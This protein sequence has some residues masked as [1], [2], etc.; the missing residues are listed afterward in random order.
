[1]AVSINSASWPT[2]GFTVL[3]TD[4]TRF[5]FAEI[6][7]VT[8]ATSITVNNR[9]YNGVN[10]SG[11][12]ASG[13][14]VML[15]SPGFATATQPG[16]LPTPPNSTS[17]WLRGDATWQGLPSNTTSQAGTVATAPNSTSQFYRGDATWAALPANST[18]QAGTV[19]TAPNDTN[20]WYR[21]DATWSFLGLATETNGTFT[22]PAAGSTV[23]VTVQSASWTAVGQ[24]LYISDGTNAGFF[25]ITVRTSATSITVKNQGYQGNSTSGTMATAALVELMGPS[26]ATS[27]QPGFVPT[28][29]NSTTQFFRGDATFATP[30]SATATTAGY[31]PT[32]PNNTTTFLR[33]DATFATPPNFTSSA[34]G[35]A[36]A[37]G[38][39]TTN[40]LRADGSW[41]APPGGGGTTYITTNSS[42]TMPAVGSTVSVTVG[43]TTDMVAGQVVTVTDGTHTA[44]MYVSSVTNSTTVVLGNNGATGNLAGSSTMNAGHVY[45]GGGFQIDNNTAHFLRGDGSFQA[46]PANSTSQA[47]T[48]STAPNS[49]TQ[50]YRGDASWATPPSATATTAG[51][52]PTPPNS[53]VQFLRGDATWVNPNTWIDALNPLLAETP[54]SNYAVFTTRNNIALLAFNDTTQ[55]SCFWTLTMPPYVNLAS[56][57]KVNL[58]WIAASATANSVVWGAKVDRAE[59]GDNPTSDSYDASTNEVTTACNATNGKISITTI[60]ITGIDSTA[61]GDM[62][63]L[64]VYRNAGSASD[65]MVGDSQLLGGSVVTAA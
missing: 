27:T 62:F 6:T 25:E 42:F 32:P 26:V 44:D 9:G 37:S 12:M 47:G 49:T 53:T 54:S 43:S 17:Q 18:S 39:G 22:I 24:T 56:G 52:V 8:S 50:F 64:Q 7:V 41:A 14:F 4:G 19:A 40:F 13:A 35:Y 15:L 5:I 46:L 21:G 63:R 45:M 28:P 23:A 58:V 29:P 2:V 61:A 33:G 36:P 60:T 38:G 55:Y 3:I 48:V 31:V 20:K 1:V 11:T 51:Y 16:F 57:I 65:N 30:P 10:V 59:A 34:A